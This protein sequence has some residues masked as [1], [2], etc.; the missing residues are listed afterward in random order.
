MCF[1]I[2]EIIKPP[3]KTRM[4]VKTI[5]MIRLLEVLYVCSQAKKLVKIR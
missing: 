2:I 3:K 4:V 5:K 1:F